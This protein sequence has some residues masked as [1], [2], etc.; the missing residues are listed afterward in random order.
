M[1]LGRLGLRL[2]LGHG[3]ATDVLTW[4][5]RWRAGA[6]ALPTAQVTAETDLAA[7][8]ELHAAAHD[9]GEHSTPD[10][11]MPARIAEAERVVTT[12]ARFAPGDARSAI[13][14]INITR[15]RQM[16]QGRTLVEFVELDETLQAVVVGPRRSR[17]VPLGAT[18]QA[19][20]AHD[21]VL[22]ALR[23]LSMLPAHHPGLANA[24]AALAQAAADVDDLLVGPLD[25]GAGDVVVVPT[26]GLHKVAWS[27]LPSLHRRSITVAPSAAWWLAGHAGP[28]EGS[29]SAPRVL[30]VEG[31]D[32]AGTT[33]ELAAIAELAPGAVKLLGADASAAAVLRELAA[34]RHRPRG[35]ARLVPRATTRCSRRCA[36]PT[37]RSG[38][39]TWPG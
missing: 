10:P 32:L 34:R 12:R 15:L 39:T 21:H 22:F 11:T 26:G 35:R 9:T 17:L 30:L 5:E 31:P 29:R 28:A 6:L 36:S 18:A 25:L 13:G 23:R 4:A 1:E 16:L 38:S 27:A 14:R 20:D 24:A 2:A 33:A 8:R 19:L 7:L 37:A 3:D